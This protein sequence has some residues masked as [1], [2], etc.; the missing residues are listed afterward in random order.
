MRK[1]LMVCTGN[2]CRSP[3]AQVLLQSLDD[4]LEVRSAGVMAAPGEPASAHSRQVARERGLDLEGHRSQPVT[5]ELLEWAD[6]VLCMTHSHRQALRQRYPELAHHLHLLGSE[7]PDPYG[8]PLAA[9]R[10]CGLALEAALRKWVE[11]NS[12]VVD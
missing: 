7:I 9:Y 8:R 10:D 1:I 3:L 11:E 4:Q 2:T 12:R 6:Q 5:R